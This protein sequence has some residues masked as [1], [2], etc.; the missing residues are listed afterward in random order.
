MKNY[1]ISVR[2]LVEFIL[3]SGDIGGAG[4][5]ASPERAW[6]GS[7]LHRK[8]Q[9]EAGPGY[10]KELSLSYTVQ[11]RPDPKLCGGLTEEEADELREGVSL[12]VEG[13]ADGL[14]LADAPLGEE[15]VQQS[16]L[17]EAAWNPAEEASPMHWEEPVPIWTVDEIK[18]VDMPLAHL[19]EDSFPLHWAQAEVYAFIIMKEKG[20]PRMQLRLSYISTEDESTRCFYRTV[21][22]EE[23]EAFWQELVGGYARFLLMQE[24]WLHTRN[25][26]LR[27]MHF[28]FSV[29]R[30]GQEQM[31]DTVRE[32]ARSG[33]RVFL[34]APTGIGKTMS[35]VYPSLEALL[36][37]DEEKIFYLT[38]KTVAASAPLGALSLLAEQGVRLKSVVI[39][40]K[41]KICPLEKRKCS[42]AACPYARGHFDHI[43]EALLTALEERD[44]YERDYLLALAARFGVCPFELSLDLSDFADFVIGDY[45]YAFDPRVALK[46]HFKAKNAYLLL[47]D[48][49]HNLVERGRGMFSAEL[50][51]SDF[52]KLKRLFPAA[53]APVLHRALTRSIKA[54]EELAQ[55]TETPFTLYERGDDPGEEFYFTL[56]R[57]SKAASAYIE[58][59]KDTP[60]GVPDELVTLFFEAL[61]F[62]RIWDSPR[63]PYEF[64][65]ERSEHD[66]LLRFFCINPAPLLQET[67]ALVRGVV[68]FSATMTPFDYYATLLDGQAPGSCQPEPGFVCLPS[69]FLPDNARTLIAPLPVTYSRRMSSTGMVCRLIEE[70][71]RARPGHYL[72]FFPSFAYMSSLYESFRR[73]CPDIPVRMQESFMDD[74]ARSRFLAAFEDTDEPFLAFCVLGGLFAEGIDLTGERLIGAI[75]VTVGLPLICPERN[76]IQMHMEETHAD[77]FAYAYTYPGW[78]RVVQ[79]AGR[80]IRTEE[81]RGVIL[82]ID[83][84]F[85]SDTY[86]SLFP[87]HWNPRTVTDETLPGVL[88]D[89]WN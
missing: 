50:R 6:E 28:P 84:R 65:T 11:L 42:A 41:D 45:N 13:R 35:A 27:Q 64:Y 51:K 12:T 61:F 17:D 29:F 54:F 8:L 43:N 79:A 76:L 78:G 82:L 34:E 63:G 80:V 4:L 16:L 18:S 87:A 32:A 67:Y 38:A 86:G 44:R 39:Y 1:R 3:R 85:L 69:P 57:F 47:V 9:Q 53:A 40:A 36:R 62:L 10:E 23:L 49:A 59:H 20:E 81:D 70:T 33:K 24:D 56:D 48:E 75:V 25:R 7:R 37:G 60:A 14:F 26:S 58:E 74:D 46:R 31:M 55:S 83:S 52:T 5:S 19:R 2:D 73:S 72:V 68:F 30:P 22:A 88:R 15:N 66:F 71:Y 77:G 89:F 21:S